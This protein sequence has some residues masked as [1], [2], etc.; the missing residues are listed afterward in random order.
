MHHRKRWW[1]ARKRSGWPVKYS[2]DFFRVDFLT[3]HYLLLDNV[4]PGFFLETLG[5]GAG[6]KECMGSR[7]EAVIGM[8]FWGKNWGILVG[9]NGD[10]RWW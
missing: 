6:T 7:V 5:D 9:F 3:F 8:G 1:V 2:P 10:H 4:A